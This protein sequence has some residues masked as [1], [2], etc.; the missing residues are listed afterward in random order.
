MNPEQAYQE[1]IRLSREETLLAS[2]I[3][4]LE[5]DEEI[6]LPR[7]AVSH[8]SDQLAFLAGLLH[9]RSTS[10]RYDELLSILEASALMSN[11]ESPPAVNVRELRRGYDR[12]RRMPKKLVEES[13]RV[14]SLASRAW[15]QARRNNDFKSFAPWLEKIFLLAREE[16]DAAGHNG[17]RYDALLDEY[18]PGMTTSVLSSLFTE[19]GD[20][21]TPLVDALRCES[22]P[23]PATFRAKRFPL[24]KQRHFAERIAAAVG[25]NL[26]AARF[27]LGNH[28]FCTDLGPGDVRIALRFASTDFTRGIFTLLHEVGHGLYDQG[29]DPAHYGTPMGEAA[30]LGLHESQSRLWEN[31][32]GRSEGFWRHFYPELQGAF[33][34]GLRDIPM[35]TFRGMI[36]RVEPG[37]IRVHADEVTYNM[38]IV[39]RFELERAML[40]GDLSVMDLP[41]AW[42]EFYQRY[43]GVTPEDDR[44]GCLQDMHWAEGLIGYFPTYALGNVYAAQLFSAAEREIG[45]LDEAFAAG[46]F[47]ELKRWLGEHV[48]RHGMRYRAAEIVERT[49]GSPPDASALI[50]GLRNRYF[51]A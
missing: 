35:E 16:A 34:R 48:H 30:S 14:T 45:P 49:T 7:K 47:V 17:T 2:C 36:N 44:N 10:P 4:V 33:S 15:V 13:A 46:N 8:R 19:L 20:K 5:W 21:L 39:I 50:A 9:D 41:G 12:E 27:D 3:D 40:S 1:L 25:F 42:G 28:P 6:N 43:L 31:L 38:H 32:V 51:A 24:D 29:L 18:E 37:L 22:K 26:D 23:G 11:A